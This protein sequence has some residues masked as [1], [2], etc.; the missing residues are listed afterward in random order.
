[1]QGAWLLGVWGLGAWDRAVW[2]RVACPSTNTISTNSSPWHHSRCRWGVS[3]EVGWAVR[4]R[5][6]PPA[7][8]PSSLRSVHFFV[9][10]AYCSAFCRTQEMGV[11][12]LDAPHILSGALLHTRTPAHTMYIFKHK[13]SHAHAHTHANTHTHTNARTHTKTRAHPQTYRHTQKPIHVHI[14][15]HTFKNTRTNTHTPRYGNH[16]LHSSGHPQYIYE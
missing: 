6:C 9:I 4:C 16:P 2:E 12:T 1:V 15:L 7:L 10:V 3:W 5:L 11:L 8:C 14:H 13:H